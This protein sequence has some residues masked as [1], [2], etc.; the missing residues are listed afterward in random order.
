MNEMRMLSWMCGATKK[1]TIRNEHK[2]GQSDTSGK[3]DNREKVEVVR[4]LEE[5]DGKSQADSI[6][7]KRPR[8]THKTRWKYS[9][10]FRRQHNYDRK[11][12]RKIRS[13]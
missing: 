9:Y 1:Y 8:G 13:P 5:E 10:L 12:S 6:P 4:A 11:N 2:R 7:E 3:E